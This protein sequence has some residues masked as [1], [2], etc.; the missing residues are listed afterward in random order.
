M[1]G[2][3]SATF[4]SLGANWLASCRRVK[5]RHGAFEIYSYLQRSFNK[6][7]P[8][9]VLVAL[10]IAFWCH[11]MRRYSP[12]PMRRPMTF[13]LLALSCAQVHRCRGVS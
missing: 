10:A 6:K 3:F 4:A 1:V 11:V 5:R 12:S 7:N 2:L 9:A 13:Q 8:V